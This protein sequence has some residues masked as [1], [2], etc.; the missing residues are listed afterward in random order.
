MR[1]LLSLSLFLSLTVLAQDIYLGPNDV[2]ILVPLPK[3]IK[4]SAL[5]LKPTDTGAYGILFPRETIDLKFDGSKGEP[6]AALDGQ[7]V[8]NPN[9]IYS[10]LRVVGI[11]LDPC[12][13][14]AVQSACKT[15]VRLAWQTIQQGKAGVRADDFAAH[16]FYEITEEDFKRIVSGL[17]SLKASTGIMSSN[18]ALE[19]HPQLQKFGLDSRYAKKLFGIFLSVIGESRISRITYAFGTQE[20][21]NWVFGGYDINNGKIQEIK[22]PRVTGIEQAGPHGL[23]QYFGNCAVEVPANVAI[24]PHDYFDDKDPT[25][26]VPG[27]PSVQAIDPPPLQG[28][29]FQFLFHA[30]KDSDLQS[31]KD[32]T[33]ST[34]RIE[35]PRIHN[36]ETIDCLSCHTAQM[37]RLWVG[38]EF[39]DLKMDDQLIQKA[40]FRSKYN[41]KNTSTH[42]EKTIVLRAFGY[43]GMNPAISQR[44]VNETAYVLEQ[45]NGK[46]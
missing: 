35:N 6:N 23:S 14:S 36:A 38:R 33:L 31:V 20:M 41:L 9:K 19:V 7:H 34:M 24:T 8:D 22:I 28:D 29:I 32:S 11:R 26:F 2:S 25:N 13:P 37:A 30:T 44:V 18:E 1:A 5:M 10:E 16:V 27:P 12:G 15:Q 43:D 46:K 42:P 3:Q 4:D 40:L 17:R 45:I 39:P 21:N